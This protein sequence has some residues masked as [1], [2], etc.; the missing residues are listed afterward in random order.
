MPLLSASTFNYLFTLELE[1]LVDH[2]V[3]NCD[4]WH[5]IMSESLALF[6][7]NTRDLS[8]WSQK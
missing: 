8:L 7:S 6:D 3:P 4:P 2:L 1:S 5:I